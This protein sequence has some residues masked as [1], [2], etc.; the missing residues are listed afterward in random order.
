[1]KKLMT[2][3]ASIALLAGMAHAEDVKLGI[4]MGLTG[5]LES[6][7]PSMV[8]GAEIAAKEV[9]DSGKFLGGS[10][11]ETVVV[12]NTCI[13]A[14]AS[15]AAVERLITSDKVNGIVGGMCSGET[16][17]SVEKVAVPNGM[18]MISPSATSPAL[19]DITDNGFFFRT[20]PSDARQ[21]EVMADLALERGVKS[22]A[23]TYTNND[24]GKGLAEAFKA[25]YEAKGGQVTTISA[26]DDG[27]A[28]YSAEVAALSAA[29][30]DALVVAGYVDQGGSGIMRAALDT[31]AFSKFI[32]PDGMVTNALE[33]K[34]GS[35]ID[36]SFGQSPSSEGEGKDKFMEIAKTNGI[37]GS[38][39][40]AGESYD[41]AALILL[42]M[43]AAKSSDPK[44]YKDKIFD[45]A[46][47][48]GEPILPGELA[49]GLELLAAGTDIDYVGATAVELVEPGE[50]AGQYREVEIKD[51][52]LN[53]VKMR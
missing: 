40:Y 46:N 33:T 32:L 38:D 11:V 48:P 3:A 17:A 36:G 51:G 30:G 34:F 24:Y 42:A 6:M 2:A 4:S 29:G 45:V 15:V 44:V 12:D 53:V 13:D 16:I 18:V 14:A 49:K 50:S 47:G 8:K 26:H 35:E 23:I 5:P 19:T 7:A 10:K 41:A 9:S 52:K 43:E 1:M 20:S 31:G 37:D 28:D 25:A 21:G 27:K 39:Q 22:V